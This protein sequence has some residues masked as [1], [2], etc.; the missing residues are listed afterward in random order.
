MSQIDN[1]LRLIG[2]HILD[3]GGTSIQDRETAMRRN[4]I[5]G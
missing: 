3:S 1:P 5:A 2:A 4:R